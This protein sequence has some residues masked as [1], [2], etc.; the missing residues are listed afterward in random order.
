[1]SSAVQKCLLGERRGWLSRVA[2]RAPATGSWQ[3]QAAG[4]EPACAPNT[5]VLL[6]SQYGGRTGLVAPAARGHCA[7]PFE[8]LVK[9]T[10]GAPY[11]L[12][13]SAWLAPLLPTAP[14]S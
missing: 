13:P 4:T 14:V 6:L 8:P 11:E 12:N 3:L 10:F 5:P 2:G 9:G 7:P 1:M